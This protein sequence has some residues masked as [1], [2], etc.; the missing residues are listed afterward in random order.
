MPNRRQML[1]IGGGGL[2]ALV[3]PRILRAAGVAE[4]TMGGTARGEHVWF[5]P[6]G[7]LVEA[8]TVLRFTN[9]DAGNSHTATC[10]HPDLFDRPLRT[11]AGATPWDSGFLLPG[12]S[13]EVPMTVPGVYDYY[14]LPHEH[15]GMVGRIVVGRP[16]DA[17]WRGA[18]TGA[19][20]LPEAAL[21]G[22]PDV[23][24][25]LTAGR[26]QQREGA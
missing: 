22:F 25:I 21:N 2:A 15:S 26:A 23:E 8:G 3:A 4:I 20:D 14:C 17:G 7:L 13:F 16:G 5:T 9:R 18:A 11:P 12:E 10:Y 6:A 24:A 19:G 1:A